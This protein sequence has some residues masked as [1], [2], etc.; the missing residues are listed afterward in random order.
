MTHLAAK[1]AG[2]AEQLQLPPDAALRFFPMLADSPA[3]H[4][5][6]GPEAGGEL[7]ASVVR[8]NPSAVEVTSSGAFRLKYGWTATATPPPPPPPPLLPPPAALEAPPA[9][10]APP[11]PMHAAPPPPAWHAAPS[12]V[13]A[14]PGGLLSMLMEPT[15]PPL[16][17]RRAHAAA[18]ASATPIT[19][20][21]PEASAQQGR[22]QETPPAGVDAARAAPSH[23]LDVL[24]HEW[25]ANPAQVLGAH[26][27]NAANLLPPP[28]VS[29]SLLPDM[30]LGELSPDEHELIRDLRP[31]SRAA[32]PQQAPA[33]AHAAASLHD[34][35]ASLRGFSALGGGLG[36]A[37]NGLGDIFM[38][39]GSLL[40]VEPSWQVAPSL[41]AGDRRA[42]RFAAPGG[43]ATNTPASFAGICD[44]LRGSAP[45]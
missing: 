26:R 43:P 6:W 34:F 9:A 27:A 10:S 39:I 24:F 29:C 11:P 32:R 15:Q 16:P 44:L 30:Y 40:G 20:A 1:W 13:A 25:S 22:Q 17:Q 18:G 2:A 45:K 36:G 31:A 37:E 5:G 12:G 3:Q 42:S 33:P 28:D 19:P 4:A 21:I 35:G 41:A 7:V 14:T 23:S 38:G 8:N